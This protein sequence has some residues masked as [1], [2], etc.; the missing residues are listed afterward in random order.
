MLLFPRSKKEQFYPPGDLTLRTVPLLPA[1]RSTLQVYQT[2]QALQ[3]QKFL[4]EDQ[5]KLLCRI[6]SA[7]VFVVQSSESTS[8]FPL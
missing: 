8:N 5:E 3:P 2:R 6:L 7:T 1:C 4:E